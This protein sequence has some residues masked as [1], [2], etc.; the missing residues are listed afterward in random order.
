M[1]TIQKNNWWTKKSD[2][3][4]LSDDL[5]IEYV[6]SSWKISELKD[7][8]E[9]FWLEKMKKIFSEKIEKNIFFREKRKKFLEF[10]FEVNKKIS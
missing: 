4:N 6:L 1:N 5:K 7:F 3:V 9:K 2:L 8:L 10:F